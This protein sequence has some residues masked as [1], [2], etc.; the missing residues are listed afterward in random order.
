MTD[1]LVFARQ[2][3]SVRRAVDVDQ[4]EALF[5]L[6]EQASDIAFVGSHLVAQP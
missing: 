1:E 2:T 5:E 4:P 6:N 3:S